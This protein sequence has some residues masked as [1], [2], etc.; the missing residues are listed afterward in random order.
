MSAPFKPQSKPTPFKPQSVQFTLAQRQAII[1][2]QVELVRMSQ[3]KITSSMGDV[4]Y[5]GSR[6]KI[7]D[8]RSNRPFSVP[9][10]HKK[11]AFVSTSSFK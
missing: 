10:P 7:N 11:N 5:G 2:K 3:P 4:A 8:F 1:T 9:F 6:L